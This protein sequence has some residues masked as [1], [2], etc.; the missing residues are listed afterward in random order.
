MSRVGCGLF[1]APK[2]KLKRLAGKPWQ[3][4][5]F[6]FKKRKLF[7]NSFPLLPSHPPPVSL[8]VC[9]SQCRIWT[10]VSN[11]SCNQQW[12]KTT[13]GLFSWPRNITN[14]KFKKRK[15][16]SLT[17]YE[18]TKLSNL[19]FFLIILFHQSSRDRGVREEKNTIMSF[20]TLTFMQV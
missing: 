3:V 18:V 19:L 14:P 11:N 9:L 13:F 16:K 7:V 5:L 2:I 15:K 8:S 6:W 4:Q 20:M 10:L 12:T 1:W 17:F